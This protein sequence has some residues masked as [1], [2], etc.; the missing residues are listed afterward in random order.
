MGMYD[1][2]EPVADRLAKFWVD[3]PTGRIETR[4]DFAG[5]AWIFRATLYREGE[6]LPASSGYARQELLAEAPLKRNGQPNTSAPEFTNPVEVCETSAI[7]RALA[8]LGYQAKAGAAGRPSR[9]EMESQ[10]RNPEVTDWSGKIRSHI[11]TIASD[12][13][14]AKRLW[15]ALELSGPIHSETAR[16]GLIATV[17]TMKKDWDQEGEF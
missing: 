5:D 12:N 4:Y 1:D 3:H 7:G 9:E 16:D 13:A 17:D 11:R 14:E 8:N 2:Y 10:S 15:E 6:E